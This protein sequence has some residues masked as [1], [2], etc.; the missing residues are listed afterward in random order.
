MKCFPVLDYEE[1]LQIGDKTRFDASKTFVA[2]SDANP[3]NALTI[4][5]GSVEYDVFN[6]DD[7]E[8]WFLDWIFDSGANDIVAGVN[9]KLDFNQSGEDRV[10][11]LTAG[12]YASLASLLAHITTQ[13]NAV[14]GISGMFAVSYA[15]GRVT[16][17]NDAQQFRLLPNGANKESS[18]L[19]HL[20]FIEQQGIQLTGATITAL[21]FEYVMKAVVLEASNI[22]GVDPEP[23]TG[24][25]K[26]VTKIVKLFTTEGD[27]LFSSDQDLI[28]WEPDIMKWVQKGRSTFLDKH[29]E[30]Q[31]QILAWLDREG[32]TDINEK[33]YTKFAIVDHKE[34]QDWS[35]FL[36]LSIIFWGISN[37]K[38][39]VFLDKF[40]AYEAKAAIARNRAVLRLDINGDGIVDV[41]EQIGIQSGTVVAR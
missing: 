2:P 36:A 5:P 37:K 38:D 7:Q 13:L 22:E 1:R 39:D 27:S 33:P 20:G 10:A 28:T 15:N 26:T 41:G 34:V 8:A 9:D 29:R 17:S 35:A 30:A 40:K 23:V 19:P 12:A 14:S 21:P 24:E 18:I 31:D 25:E 32:Y 4:K 16:I 3:V 6:A 11:T